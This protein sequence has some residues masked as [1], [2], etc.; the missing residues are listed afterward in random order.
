L[1]DLRIE[2][3]TSAELLYHPIEVIEPSP[4]GSTKA[5]SFS[6]IMLLSLTGKR[7][8]GAVSLLIPPS[9][10]R[11]IKISKTTCYYGS[12]FLTRLQDLN[13]PQL[14]KEAR[15]NIK[16]RLAMP[17]SGTNCRDSDLPVPL[18]L[19]RQTSCSTLEAPLPSALRP[20]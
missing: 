20:E 17:E 19:W 9:R 11:R 7:Q 1:Q 14:D 10:W 18:L 5:K 3:Y 16:D 2:N 13:S 8:Q 15:Q 4:S 6:Y 12:Y